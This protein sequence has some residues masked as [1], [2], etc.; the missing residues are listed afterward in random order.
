MQAKSIDTSASSKIEIILS[1]V[2]G[3]Q[4]YDQDG[5]ANGSD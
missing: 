5:Y 4:Q 3:N 1:D 2:V